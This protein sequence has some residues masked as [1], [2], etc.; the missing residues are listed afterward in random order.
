MKGVPG[1]CSV[2]QSVVSDSATPWTAPCQASLFFTIS[3]SLLRLVT[4]ESM[5]PSSHLILCCPSSSCLQ[6]LPASFQVE[7]MTISKALHQEQAHS[8]RGI[9]RRPVWLGLQDTLGRTAFGL[10]WFIWSCLTLDD[11][12]SFVDLIFLC[13]D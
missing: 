7:G 8:I 4:T 3:G 5:M 6:S 13:E 9:E 10:C 1:S 2:A 12:V 11:S